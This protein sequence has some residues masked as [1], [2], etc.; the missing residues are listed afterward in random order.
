MASTRSDARTTTKF[1]YKYIFVR[2][3]LPIEIV[4]DQGTHFINKVVQVL[5]KEFLVTH[6]R[7]APY[8]PQANN[9]AELTNKVLCAALTK[10]VEGNRGS[11]EHKLPSVLWAYRIAYKTLI[12]S[13]LFKLVCGLNAKLYIEFLMPIL[14][15]GAMLHW[16]SHALSKRLSKLENL[17]ER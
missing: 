6:R 17:D 16:D 1:L 3:G 4:S 10:V 15:I 13:T 5:L 12:G 14:Q 9:Q 7:H 8:H 11:W 2:F